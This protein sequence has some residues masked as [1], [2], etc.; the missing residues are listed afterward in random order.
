[1]RN[2]IYID[3]HLIFLKKVIRTFSFL[4][5]LFW[6]NVYSA[7]T[8][9]KDFWVMFS[10][11]YQTPSELTLFISSNVDTTVTVTLPSVSPQVYSV[12]AGT[13]LSVNVPVSYISNSGVNTDKGIHLESDDSIAVY[14]LNKRRASTDAYLVLPVDAYG[15]KYFSTNYTYTTTYQTNQINILSPTD[16]NFVTVTYPDS[17][18]DTFTLDQGENYLIEKNADLTGS[19]IEST[20][21]VFVTNGLKCANVPTT[22]SACDHVVESVF[23]V[24]AIST[25][26]TSHPLATRTQGDSY[27]IVATVD[28][29]DVFIDGTLVATLMAGEYYEPT[30]A[31]TPAPLHFTA[32]APVYVTQYSNGSSF[33]GVTSDPFMM[34]LIPDDQFMQEYIINTAD[35]GSGDAHYVNLVVP[36]T[37]IGNILLD[38]VAISSSVFSATP[39]S[40]YY[41]ASLNITEGSHHF[42]SVSGQTRFAVYVYGFA[43]ADSY[44][45]P[46]GAQVSNINSIILTMTPPIATKEISSTH[47]VLINL[48]DSNN[49]PVTF[50]IVDISVSGV[51]S[52]ITTDTTDSNGDIN[53]C[54]TGSVIGMDTITA[55]IASL[56]EAV[57][58]N[59]VEKLV[60]ADTVSKIPSSSF[61]TMLLLFSLL[62]MLVKRKLLF[63]R[64][65]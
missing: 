12:V 4:L 38:G 50:T 61:W 11:N 65:G 30:P 28:N 2:L 54:Y 31:A 5:L 13:T 60:S 27:R 7:T 56:S 63:Y 32:S 42:T 57:T 22:A 58:V 45:Y 53:Y 33:D 17:T 48:T 55:S 19:L 14:A 10:P 23:P 37:D 8:T 6:G 35:M 26:Y 44:G 9:G 24:D 51:N 43:S 52:I 41:S 40:S 59:W 39:N 3:K 29:T 34:D 15:N 47:C 49:Q 64:V 20:S 21:P 62:A 25:S 1:M 18:I 36:S 46:G 16:G